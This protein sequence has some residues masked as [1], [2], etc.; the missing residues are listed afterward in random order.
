MRVV[1]ALLV[2]LVIVSALA[3]SQ[4]Q[5][6]PEP[7]TASVLATPGGYL[8]HGPPAYDSGWVDLRPNSWLTLEHNVGGDPDDY[9]VDLQFWDW[10]AGSDGIGVHHWQYGSDIATEGNGARWLSLTNSSIDIRAGAGGVA[11]EFVEAAR[12]RIWVA[13]PAD[14]DSG[15]QA[16]DPGED[17]LFRHNLGGSRQDYVVDLQFKNTDIAAYGVHHDHYGGQ[18]WDGVIT[19][20][21]YW[22]NLTRSSIQVHRYAGDGTTHEV[23]VRIWRRPN[24]AFDS[25]WVAI[26]DEISLAHSLGGPWNDTVVD[27]QFKDT[28]DGYGVNQFGYG[29]DTVFG[30]VTEYHGAYWTNLNG[31]EIQVHRGADDLAADQVRVR[32]W[33]S[34]TPKY[35]SGWFSLGRPS[36]RTLTH[37]L[38]GITDAYKIELQYRDT[39]ADGV[40]GFGVNHAYEGGDYWR[41]PVAADF[42]IQGVWWRS[43]TDESVFVYRHGEDTGADEVRVRLWI[44]PE[45]AYDSG[46]TDI[47]DTLRLNHGLQRHP[48]AMVVDLQF[49]DDVGESPNGVN[50]RGYGGDTY[51][52]EHSELRGRGAYWHD[53]TSR[54]IAVTRLEH[55][56]LADKVRV[57]I[58]LNSQFDYASP[59][60]SLD[61]DSRLKLNHNL[62]SDP[63]EIVVDM[64]FKDLD[65]SRPH[66]RNYGGNN[67]YYGKL[68]EYGAR[69]QNLTSNSIKVHRGADDTFA[70]EARVRI[71]RTAGSGDQ[72]FLPLI[73]RP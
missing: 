14:Y 51:F 24:P 54:S 47:V 44:V 23:R 55:A 4:A 1:A 49:M 21:A 32:I 59:W 5:G 33:A 35:D 42:V 52:N 41:D 16:V 53:L 65:S 18:N 48:N 15:W 29:G 27:L 72:V 12:V 46:W 68:Y 64:Q 22:H 62:D 19:E 63:G 67:L 45:P 20:G 73:M 25:G 66:Q 71:W 6:Q 56:D 2:S 57:R 43:L 40:S 61:P 7:A 58:W 9:V 69:W 37:N 31:T 39:M 34:R 70:E 50:N 38:G 3:D 28:D 10:H 26:T 13:P 11:D 17:K 60:Q 8:L 36:F 30:A